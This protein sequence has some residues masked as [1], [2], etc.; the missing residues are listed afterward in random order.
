MWN[1]TLIAICTIYKLKNKK[2]KDKL[3]KL[4]LNDKILPTS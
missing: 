4:C 1:D 3:D 2:Y